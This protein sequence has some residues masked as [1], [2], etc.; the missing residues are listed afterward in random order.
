[1][2]IQI[3]YHGQCDDGFGS[4]YAAW[5]YFTRNEPNAKISYTPVFYGKP[6]PA[7]KPEDII[8]I[9]DFSYNRKDLMQ[10][11]ESCTNLQVLDHHKT[12]EKELAGLPYCEFDMERSGAVITWKWFHAASFVPNLLLFIQDNDLWK[13]RLGN[14]KEIIR[15]IRSK[16]YDFE[17][18]ERLE[19]EFEL[20]MPQVISKGVA[21]EGYFQS[22]LQFNLPNH[23]IIEFEGQKFP[24]INTNKTFVSEMLHLL[25]EEAN[26]DAAI[27]YCINQGMVEFSL[28]GRNDMDVSEI[29]KK[30]GGGGHKYAAG[31]NAQIGFLHTLLTQA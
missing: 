17:T 31:F 6:M 21:I 9:C 11:K 25:M 16:P 12:A 30:Y 26:T 15:Y 2:T 10:L 4:A 23:H 29:A 3:W 24:I 19:Q 5:K 1:M 27:G 7:Y 20:N 8:Y 18:W 22:A 13:H 28:R 14:C